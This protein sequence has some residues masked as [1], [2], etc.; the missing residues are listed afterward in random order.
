MRRKHTGAKT[1]T[2]LKPVNKMKQLVGMPK[3]KELK[4]PNKNPPKAVL[5]KI[6]KPVNLAKTVNLVKPVNPV[7]I[8]NPVNFVKPVDL[9]KMDGDP[10]KRFEKSQ[11]IW[12][13]PN[14]SAN[15]R[16]IDNR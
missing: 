10:P 1:K 4:N 16:R 7:K 9:F 12:S 5:V 11:R 6:V 14:A 13:Q 15:V 2:V 3:T 8:I